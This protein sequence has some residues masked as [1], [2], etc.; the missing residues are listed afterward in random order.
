MSTDS[1]L[2]LPTRDGGG[3]TLIFTEG[4]QQEERRKKNQAKEKEARTKKEDE[5]KENNDFYLRFHYDCEKIFSIEDQIRFSK[6]RSM[7]SK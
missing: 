5:Y 6:H 4:R 1:L 7:N 3:T 2:S